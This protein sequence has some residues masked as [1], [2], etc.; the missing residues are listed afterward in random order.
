MEHDVGNAVKN[1]CSRFLNGSPKKSRADVIADTE[2]TE[3]IAAPR[4]RTS[5]GHNTYS[6]ESHIGPEIVRLGADIV[7]GEL[8]LLENNPRAATI[9]CLKACSFL[10]IAKADFLSMFGNKINKG[11]ISLFVNNVP[12]FEEWA[13]R[14]PL[15]TNISK[16]GQRT[17][18]MEAHPCDLFN[19]SIVNKGQY[20]FKEGEVAEPRII[21]LDSGEI[22]FHKLS[23]Q[24]P[25]MTPLRATA[26]WETPARPSVL[27]PVKQQKA[28][29]RIDTVWHRLSFSGALFC[30]LEVFELPCAEPFSVVASTKCEIYSISGIHIQKLPESIYT[31]I[32]RHAVE[33]LRPLLSQAPCF[34]SIA[35]M[36]TF[37]QKTD[38][39][40]IEDFDDDRMLK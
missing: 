33:R 3:D 25:R 17:V 16:S 1:C 24:F 22:E 4:H 11:K 18:T 26:C 37:F 30:S 19:K 38:I 36:P 34:N 7:F 23:Y 31:A 20:F 8:G 14:N 2:R 27:K 15:K 10:V 13:N 29:K 35:S 28:L 9:K 12:G 32:K 21:V 5:E 40:E 39:A 6:A